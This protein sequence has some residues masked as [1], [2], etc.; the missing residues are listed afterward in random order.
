MKSQ[1]NKTRTTLLMVINNEVVSYLKSKTTIKINGQSP[2]E[3]L[4]SFG[5][6]EIIITNPIITSLGS[7]DNKKT[8]VRRGISNNFNDI[9][10]EFSDETSNVKDELDSYINNIN[11]RKILFSKNKLKNQLNC[12]S[13]NRNIYNIQHQHSNMSNDDNLNINNNVNTIENNIPLTKKELLHNTMKQAMVTLKTI[14][15]NIKNIRYRHNEKKQSL[16]VK[17]QLNES[18]DPQK[19]TSSI[20]SN[21]SSTSLKK[22]RNKNNIPHTP[23]SKH[24]NASISPSLFTSQHSTT[25]ASIINQK[26]IKANSSTE[27]SQLKQSFHKKNTYNAKAKGNS[28]FKIDLIQSA[29]DLFEDDDDDDDDDD[30]GNKIVKAPIYAFA[31]KE[32]ISDMNVFC[33]SP[34]KKLNMFRENTDVNKKQFKKSKTNVEKRLKEA[35]KNKLMDHLIALCPKKINDNS[36]SD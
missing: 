17:E 6:Y 1:A 33:Y 13:P 20:T 11:K 24:K 36:E 30:Q 14:T 10:K 15:N 34:N 9:I 2:T 25:K 12:K 28:E 26:N 19:S 31:Q 16:K 27:I 23:K 32:T 21:E 5:K 8:T 18:P 3:Q 4:Q 7:K 29:S 22:Q 35:K